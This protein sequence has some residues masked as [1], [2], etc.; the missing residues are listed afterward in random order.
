VQQAAEETTGETLS[1]GKPC[2]N[3]QFAN[4]TQAERAQANGVGKRTQEKLDRLARER[5]D[6]HERV[7]AGELSAPRAR[8]R[9]F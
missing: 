2:N 1:R 4:L 7:K 6:L 9:L 8:A 5:P 3:S